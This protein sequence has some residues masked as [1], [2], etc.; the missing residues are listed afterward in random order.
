MAAL[1]IEE[2]EELGEDERLLRV[3]GQAPVK[4][5]NSVWSS[6]TR[7]RMSNREWWWLVHSML[8]VNIILNVTV[9]LIF[10][11][12]VGS[13]VALG[14]YAMLMIWSLVMSSVVIFIVWRKVAELKHELQSAWLG[15]ELLQI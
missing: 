12:K 10:S 2:I 1:F 4:E 9:F 7:H 3:Q 11:L 8:V 13:R 6:P 14:F 5:T 15:T